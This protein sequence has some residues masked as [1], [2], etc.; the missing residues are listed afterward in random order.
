MNSVAADVEDSFFIT[1]LRPC[2]SA[3]SNSCHFYF[4][5]LEGNFILCFWK[6]PLGDQS[7]IHSGLWLTS[8]LCY[9]LLASLSGAAQFLDIFGQPCLLQ[10]S[11]KPFSFLKNLSQA[12]SHY[13]M[14]LFKADF[15]S[16]THV[17]IKAVS[18]TIWGHH[19]LILFGRGP[20]HICCRRSIL[21][22]NI[23]CI[24][25]NYITD[26]WGNAPPHK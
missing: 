1:F 21:L 26:C 19:S 11:F 22:C 17:R 13:C 24:Y 5:L 4:S 18:I 9:L 20:G 12:H 8:G 10:W 23:I 25:D 2:P 6:V 7:W 3:L 15:K 16:R 14:P